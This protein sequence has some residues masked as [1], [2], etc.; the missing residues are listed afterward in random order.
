MGKLIEGRCLTDAQV[1][2]FE[3][4]QYQEN[5]GH[6]QRGTAKFRNWITAD[7]SEGESGVGGFKAETGRY[8]LFAALN[9]PWAHRT[10]IYRSIKGLED[11]ISCSLVKPLRNDQGWVFDKSG[12]FSDDLYQLE[13]MHSLY[14]KAAPDYTGRVTVPVLWDKQ[15]KKIVSTE[16]SEIIRMF[17]QAFYQITNN[18]EDYYPQQLAVEIDEL[19]Q[20]IYDNLNN[21]V[22]QAG[23]ARSQLAYD[24]AVTKVFMALETIEARLSTSS[25]LLGEHVTEADWRLLPTLVRFDVGYY[26]AFKCNIKAIR[27]YPNLTRYLQR[28]VDISGVSQ[29]I[30][31]D[32]YRKGYHSTSSLRNPHGIVPVGMSSTFTL[33]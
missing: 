27:D 21:G 2:A 30:D 8:H 29:T 12:R 13:N 16:S 32:V 15:Q 18:K 7:G 5:Q 19:N 24:E 4:Q 31:L 26:S 6:F 17:N 25:F 1:D 3:K 33:T 28:L 20:F 22:Y 23:F 9:C 11:V 10:L 14:S